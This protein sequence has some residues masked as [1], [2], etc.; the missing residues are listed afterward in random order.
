MF[1]NHML[2]LHEKSQNQRHSTISLSVVQFHTRFSLYHVTAANSQLPEGVFSPRARSSSAGVHSSFTRVL[3]QLS[4]SRTTGN[5]HLQVQT[6]SSEKEKLLW[7]G[8]NTFSVLPKTKE[9]TSR[10]KKTIKPSSN[11]SVWNALIFPSLTWK[12]Q[13]HFKKKSL[14][15]S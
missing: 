3:L 11:P 12:Q 5:T 9:W 10:T 6:T 7:T 4:S 1:P 2:L 8:D 15:N 13:D 14:S